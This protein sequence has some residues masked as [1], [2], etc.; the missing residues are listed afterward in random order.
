MSSPRVSEEEWEATRIFRVGEA[1]RRAMEAE[2]DALGRRRGEAHGAFDEATQL[3]RHLIEFSHAMLRDGYDDERKRLTALEVGVV[4]CAAT[5]NSRQ[6]SKRVGSIRRVELGVFT[7]ELPHL[8]SPMLIPRGR[9]TTRLVP[10]A[11]HM[12]D[13]QLLSERLL[14]VAFETAF[15]TT[16]DGYWCSRCKKSLHVDIVGEAR[17]QLTS[18]RKVVLAHPPM[19]TADYRIRQLNRKFLSDPENLRALEEDIGLLG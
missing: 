11:R 9:E 15:E 13:E 10:P 5:P 4:R 19:N 3:V 14:T 12:T 8:N 6:C 1:A 18:G 2:L 7:V 17:R 16:G